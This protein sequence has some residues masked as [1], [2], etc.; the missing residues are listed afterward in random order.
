MWL[1]KLLLLEK[2]LTKWSPHSKLVPVH[3]KI[4]VSITLK[5]TEMP[6]CTGQWSAYYFTEADTILFLFLTKDQPQ[7]LPKREHISALT[8]PIFFQ[9]SLL[10]FSLQLICSAQIFCSVWGA[11]EGGINYTARW[12]RARQPLWCTVSSMHSLLPAALQLQGSPVGLG[13]F[14]SWGLAEMTESA[15][16]ESQLLFQQHKWGKYKNRWW[17]CDL[18]AARERQEE[19]R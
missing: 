2:S 4:L 11:G 15:R 19:V 1:C 18:A 14:P 10:P 7:F 16:N 6:S 17:Q 8:Q 12:S 5:F 9:D 13:T 3:I